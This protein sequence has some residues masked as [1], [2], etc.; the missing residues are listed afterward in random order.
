VLNVGH[1]NQISFIHQG[2]VASPGSDLSCND[3]STKHS[4]LSKWTDNDV[5]IKSSKV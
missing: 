3:K 2:I 5:R 4:R 1:Q